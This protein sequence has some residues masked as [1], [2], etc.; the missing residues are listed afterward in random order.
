MAYSTSN[1]PSLVTQAINGR[2]IWF[3]ASTDPSTD[4]DASG[5]FT[6]G[7][8]LGMRQGDQVL[9]L[10]TDSTH[11]QMT[12][13]TVKSAVQSTGVVNLSDGVSIGGAAD[14]D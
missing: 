12:S 3:Y 8:A 11:Q 6:N 14:A 9:V 13:H 2:R 7:Y 10:D 5:Y 4:V 1:P